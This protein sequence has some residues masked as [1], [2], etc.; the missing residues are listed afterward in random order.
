MSQKLF[1]VNM[2]VSMLPKELRIQAL[3][4]DLTQKENQRSCQPR[5]NA[6]VSMRCAVCESDLHMLGERS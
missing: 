3:T 2:S 1:A 4:T 6:I 5:K